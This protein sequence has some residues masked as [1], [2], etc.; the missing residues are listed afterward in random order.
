MLLNGAAFELSVGSG[1]GRTEQL[2]SL[3]SQHPE[4]SLGF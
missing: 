2:F 4:Q 3:S 1:G